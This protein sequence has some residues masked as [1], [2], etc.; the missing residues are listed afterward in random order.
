MNKLINL[1][2]ILFLTSFLTLASFC[3]AQLSITPNTSATALAQTILGSGVSVGSANLNCG[4]TSAG[5]FT[6]T[7][8]DLGLSNGILLTN[9]KAV[10]AGNPAVFA[11]TDLHITFSDPYLISIGGTQAKYDVCILTFTFVTVCDSISIKYVFGSEEYPKYINT[12]NDAFGIFLSGPN[13]CGATYAGT[14]IA[15][16]PNGHHTAVSIDSVNG[17]FTTAQGATTGSNAPIAASNPSYYVNNFTYNGTNYTN[18]GN[19]ELSYHGFTIPITSSACVQP[20][21]TY[22][23]EIA[24]ADGSNGNYDS[25]IFIQ[26]NSVGCAPTTSITAST[27]PSNCGSNN[28][29]A[30]VTVTNFSGIPTYSWSPGGNLTSTISGLTAGSYSCI[31]GLPVCSA[32]TYTTVV[33]TV[34]GST[35]AVITIANDTICMGTAATLVAN[36][37]TTYTWNTGTTG[38]TFTIANVNSNTSYTVTGTSASGCTNTAVGHIIVRNPPIV[39]VNSATINAGSTATLTASG[40]TSYT[41]STSATTDSIMVSPAT[42]T[43]YTVIGIDAHSCINTAVAEVVVI[44]TPTKIIIPNIFTP[45]GDGTNDV[46]FITAT[47][48][49]NF[50]CTIY[51]RW[52]L[53][54]Y[55]WTG[56]GG[57]WNGKAKDGNNCTDGVYF[58]LISYDD[59]AGKLSKKDGFFELIR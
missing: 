6:D 53:L 59:N 30:S 16:L 40:A 10:D 33:V 1:R 37:A 17:G 51:N 44:Q 58:Y 55:E 8:T 35:P 25:G 48:I 21:Q 26:G 46:F 27:T 49:S 29:T 38:A 52:G 45:N 9:G 4:A 31:V 34:A 3:F 24:I 13:P 41:W 56:T 43:N 50:K 54:L 12:Y 42:S 36:G 57:G 2:L 22:T 20:C 11:N 19:G 5:T 7:G 32:T 47:G 14:D 23:M 39:T 18:H 15:T 28:G